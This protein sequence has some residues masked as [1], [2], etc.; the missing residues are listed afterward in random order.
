MAA[1]GRSPSIA[2]VAALA[3]V[4]HQT[5]SRVLNDH[6]NV[7]EQTRMRVRAAIAEL[8]YRPNQ[9]AR[10]LARGQANLIGIVAPATT[11]Y[12]PTMMRTSIEQQAADAGYGVSVSTVRSLD[13]AS[14]TEAVSRLLD[15]RV[16]GVVVI[17]PV[18]AVLAAVEA[19]PKGFPLVLIDGDPTES[20]PTAS[21]DQ[22]TGARLATEHLLA[23]GHRTVWH[24]CGPQETFDARD[25]I[26]GWRQALEAAGADVPPLITGD[27]SA[28][29][30]FDAGQMLARMSDVTAVFTANDQ[31]A[32]GVLRALAE[33]GV[34]VPSEVSVV[35]FDDLP[36]SAFYEPPLTTVRQEFTEV[37]VLALR[38]LIAQMDGQDVRGHDSVAPEL[39]TRASVAPPSPA[40]LAAR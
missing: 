21:V 28:Q 2:D 24:V 19:V 7:R 3:G 39:V 5:V 33:H 10:A 13:Q 6:P 9:A 30:G 32:L 11:L 20:V 36:E 14:L 26:V 8:G 35:G 4:S 18:P 34:S 12:G 38:S 31:M 25:R 16:G 22:V 17:A 40:R 29:S 27:W 1:N 37:A 15:Q 23:Q